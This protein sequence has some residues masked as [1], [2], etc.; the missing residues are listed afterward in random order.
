MQSHRWEALGCETTLASVSTCA[1]SEASSI[2]NCCETENVPLASTSSFSKCV[3]PTEYPTGLV[4]QNTF[5]HFVIKD[6]ALL[7]DSSEER[8][9]RSAPGSFHR[10]FRFEET[11]VQASAS[12]TPNNCCN[13][14]PEMGEPE[15]GSLELP[16][17]GSAQHHAGQC[18]PCAFYWKD[19]G[20]SNG[21]QCHFCHLCD[22][23][24]KRR[25]AKEKKAWLRSLHDGT[26]N[27]Q[28]TVD[29]GFEKIAF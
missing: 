22:E 13:L 11:P 1:S 19:S 4:I 21:V 6:P 27:V 9:V 26:A 18:K 17:V 15:L 29:A 7:V 10:E 12:C 16:T 24:E 2:S 23:K 5:L 20:C 14:A 8:S 3:L 28:D 25:R